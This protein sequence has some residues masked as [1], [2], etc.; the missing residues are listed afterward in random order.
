MTQRFVNVGQAHPDSKLHIYFPYFIVGTWKAKE[1]T[2]AFMTK[3]HDFLTQ[4][5]TFKLRYAEPKRKHRMAVRKATRRR[6]K[7]LLAQRRAELAQASGSKMSFSL[8]LSQGPGLTEEPSMSPPPSLPQT[9]PPSLGRRT[10]S[11]AFLHGGLSSSSSS[12]TSSFSSLTSGLSSP[13]TPRPL[14]PASPPPSPLHLPSPSFGLSQGRPN[15]LQ[16]AFSLS[17][18]SPQTTRQPPRAGEEQE[19]KDSSTTPTPLSKLEHQTLVNEIHELEEALESEKAILTVG[20]GEQ[21]HPDGSG[22]TITHP[23]SV[24]LMLKDPACV[25]VDAGIV[26]NSL[27]DIGSKRCDRC[28]CKAGCEKCDGKRFVPRDPFVYY[29]EMVINPDGTLNQ[30]L[31]SRLGCGLTRPWMRSDQQMMTLVLTLT[32][33]H[34]PTMEQRAETPGYVRPEN[35]PVIGPDATFRY[36]YHTKAM[37]MK[38]SRERGERRRATRFCIDFPISDARVS[39]VAKE[40]QSFHPDYASLMVA[41]LKAANDG[42]ILVEVKGT[43]SRRCPNLPDEGSHHGKTV[44]FYLRKDGKIELRCHC[45]C[46]EHTHRV[47]HKR[48][49]DFSVIQDMSD[50]AY[51]ILFPVE[52]QTRQLK[53]TPAGL[54]HL[55]LTNQIAKTRAAL[56]KEGRVFE[57]KRKQEGTKKQEAKKDEFLR[58]RSHQTALSML[59]YGKEMP[60]IASQVLDGRREAEGLAGR[61]SCSLPLSVC[62]YH[63]QW[64]L[65]HPHPQPSPNI[66]PTVRP[67]RPGQRPLRN[68]ERASDAARPRP[69]V[70]LRRLPRPVAPAVPVAGTSSPI[71]GVPRALWARSENEPPVWPSRAPV[72]L[73]KLPPPNTRWRPSGLRSVVGGDRGLSKAQPRLQLLPP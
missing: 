23:L 31:Q 11:V 3:V 42:T 33:L 10:S 61:R 71:V 26:T 52:F 8:A 35:V 48:C 5:L 12:L 56:E 57:K 9:T 72:C 66:G 45:V 37:K 43:G 40:A 28:G 29:P 30:K 73:R 16:R 51:R 13:M 44:F 41:S 60:S 53:S 47:S 69:G 17:A 1:I 4:S 58:R 39:I 54:G 67:R 70:G 22:T 63:P 65:R 24:F 32:S 18:I 50:F 7:N 64:H 6:L 19:A 14:S 59:I 49:R 15:A 46:E 38:L 25:A 2:H 62:S 21:E 68:Q 55:R 36:A 20:Y 27:R 34:L